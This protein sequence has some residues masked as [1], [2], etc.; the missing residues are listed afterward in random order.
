MSDNHTE[1]TATTHNDND[2]RHVAGEGI[3]GASGAMAGAIVGSVAGPIGSI[4]GGAAGAI[5]GWWAGKHA[6]DTAPTLHKYDDTYREYHTTRGA[7]GEYEKHRPAYQVGHLASMNPEYKGRTFDEVS[8]DLERSWKAAT[9]R[10]KLTDWS[11]ASESARYSYERRPEDAEVS[12]TSRM[13][14]SATRGDNSK[15][16]K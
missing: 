12:N 15:S 14:G 5:G 10:E 16:D 3:G 2:A 4:I 8:P 9:E 13:N 6:L 11:E 7:K 1:R